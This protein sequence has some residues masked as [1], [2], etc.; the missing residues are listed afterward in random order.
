[1]QPQ[2]FDCAGHLMT[3]RINP[4]CLAGENSHVMRDEVS[5]RVRMI[6]G[7][8]SADELG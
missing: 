6:P 2:P 5:S 3:Y 7:S 1:L 8:V 4:L